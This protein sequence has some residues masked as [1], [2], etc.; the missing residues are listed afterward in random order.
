MLSDMAEK[1]VFVPGAGRVAGLGHNQGRRIWN[2][3]IGE[4]RETSNELAELETIKE[5]DERSL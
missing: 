2:N 3:K 4:R 5:K 1:N